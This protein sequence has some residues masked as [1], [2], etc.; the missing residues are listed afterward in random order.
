MKISQLK[1]VQVDVKTL[2][3][4]CKVCDRFTYMLKDAQGE[5][6]FDQDDGYVP[7]FMPGDHYGDY[8]ILN[9][10]L[11]TGKVTNWTTPTAE[12]IEAV[13]NRDDD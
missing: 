4:Y 2:E 7:D 10:D 9:I 3:I 6:V 1:Q 13:I 8:I 11:E 12:Q 5:T